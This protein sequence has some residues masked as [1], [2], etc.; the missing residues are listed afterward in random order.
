M[1]W[2][3]RELITGRALDR[4]SGGRALARR[5]RRQPPGNG[6]RAGWAVA[7]ILAAAVTLVVVVREVLDRTED[8]LAERTR[9]AMP[10]RLPTGESM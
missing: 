8:P 10:A 4:P 7:G 2:R 5:R 1:L 3:Q 9:S 6:S